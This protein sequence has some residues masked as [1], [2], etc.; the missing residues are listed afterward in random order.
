[1]AQAIDTSTFIEG[2]KVIKIVHSVIGFFILIV[3]MFFFSITVEGEMVQ[4]IGYK[5]M[6]IVFV[7]IGAYYVSK[8]AKTGYKKK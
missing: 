4:T 2:G 8:V 3:G 6:G 5:L 7:T 1:M